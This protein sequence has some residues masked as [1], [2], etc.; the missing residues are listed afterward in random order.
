MRTICILL[1]A[2][3]ALWSQVPDP[4]SRS[5]RN[6]FAAQPDA[7]LAGRNLFMASCSGCHGANAEGGRGPNLTEGRQIRRLRDGALFASIKSGVPGT[8]M[9]PSN[10]AEDQIWRLVAFVRDLS[11]AAYESKVAGDAEQGASIFFGKG[12]C[13]DC[14]MI[15]GRGGFI[16]P[17][18]TDIGALR[19]VPQLRESLL[20]P[21]A[22]IVDGY[23][24][25]TVTLRDGSKISGVA[26]NSNNYSMQILDAKGSLRLLAT[27]ELRAVEFRKSSLMPEDYGKRLASGEIDNVLAFL[28][29]Q[30]VRPPGE[31]GADPRSRG[32]RK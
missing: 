22:R 16:G 5:E 17:D 6:P 23:E 24:G 25:V 8:D 3:S 19:T 1:L 20:K 13:S 12:G 7:I 21:S 18:L 30:S 26:R 15:R 31:R 9:P 4:D 11:A 14:H 28:S 29:R 10:L 27:D 32:N 2:A